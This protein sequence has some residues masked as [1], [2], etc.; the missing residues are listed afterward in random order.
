M[1]KSIQDRVRAELARQDKARKAAEYKA[2][3][4]ARRSDAARCAADTRKDQRL[5]DLIAGKVEPRNVR[6]LDIVNRVEFGE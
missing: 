5:D 2:G 1:T 3:E 6:E 4:S